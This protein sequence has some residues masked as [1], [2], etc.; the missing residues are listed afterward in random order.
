VNLR[1]G[2]KK[3]FSGIFL[4]IFHPDRTVKK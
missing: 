4:F 3:N 2:R 1:F